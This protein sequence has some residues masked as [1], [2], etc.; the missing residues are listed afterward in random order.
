[1][2]ARPADIKGAS[3][4][5]LH[6]AQRP[7]TAGTVLRSMMAGL[8]VGVVA[9]VFSISFAAI[10]YTG[11]MAP[12][13]SRGIGLTLAGAAVMA[14]VGA[15]SLSYRGTIV[16]PQDVTAITLALAVASIAGNWSAGTSGDLFATAAVLVAIATAVTGI[17]CLTFGR[18]RLGFIVRFIPYP[19]LGGFLAAT[20]YLLITGAIGMTL[21]RSFSLSAVDTLF[22][23]SNAVKWMPWIAAGILFHAI[24]R[25]YGHG[26]VL[27][28]CILAAVFGFYAVLWVTGV[29]L[30]KARALGLLLGPFDAAS[31]YETL[32]PRILAQANWGVIAQHL[33]TLLTV[34]GMSAIGVLLNASAIELATGESIDPDRE[35]RGVGITNLAAS[36]LGGLVGY[37]LLGETLFARALGVADRTAGLAVAV[38]TAFA[39][40]FGAA[41][42]SVLPIGI[43]AAVIAFLGIDLIVGWLWFERR[44]LPVRDFLIVLFIL[45]VAATIGFLPAIAT[46]TL[47]A[48][49]FFIFAYA[50]IGTVRIKT[51]AA[52]TR[53]HVERGAPEIAILSEVGERVAIY[54]LSGYLFFGTA[55]RMLEEVAASGGMTKDYAVLDFRRVQ[56]IDASAAF[57]LRKLVKETGPAGLT[58]VF[59][60]LPAHLRWMLER[61]G[62]VADGKTFL[63]VDHLNDGLEMIED[64]LI[65]MYPPDA[66]AD[67]DFLQEL[68]L[69]HPALDP[70]SIFETQDVEAGEVVIEQDSDADGIAFL[71]KGTLRV[72]HVDGAGKA[73]P[74]AKILPG[75]LVGEVGF[76]AGTA[77]T[78]RVTADE[79][80][81]LL[82]LSATT[83]G[84]LESSEP[85]LLA[86]IHRLAA[87]H[88]S[89]RLM[90][91]MA[92]LRDADL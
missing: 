24:S 10:I 63:M 70:G 16:Q 40:F 31:F 34:V 17:A 73:T 30:D 64:R 76:Y 66:A 12:Y 11:E 79:D 65:E 44:R 18:L 9:I 46:G 6:A 48:A 69:S 56:G 58:I 57:A 80:C 81:R 27:P 1:M 75:A 88:L 89:R 45:V 47:V 36:L 4:G 53:S 72:E 2:T 86:D 25:R 84:K 92:L 43:F 52:S 15:F 68:R 49:I 85:A 42:L 38:V 29:D 20:G 78:A 60:G 90:R 5:E 91:T 3:A 62:V 32:D 8:I 22:T 33:P 28:L 51:T 41:Y 50:A 19:V 39:L 83:L 61:S 87:A 59:T 82:R 13:L 37:H 77:R 14:L 55:G 26:L 21:G 67:A 7:V 35:L 74:V 71:V 23:S 54:E